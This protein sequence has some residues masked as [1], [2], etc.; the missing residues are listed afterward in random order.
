MTQV[1]SIKHPLGMHNTYWPMPDQDTVHIDRAK[2]SVVHPFMVPLLEVLQLKRPQWEFE[3]RGYGNFDYDTN[4]VKH[5]TFTIFDNGEKL[6]TIER[7][8]KS[9]S[10]VYCATNHR[11]SNKRQIGTRKT[12]KHLKT[13]VSEVLKEFY[14]L[15]LE[16]LA[17]EK[18]RKAYNATQTATHKVRREYARNTEALYEPMLK[19]LTSGGRWGEFAAVTDVPAVMQAKAEYHNLAGDAHAATEIQK[20]YHV[21]LIERPRDIVVKPSHG[22][23]FSTSLDKLPDDIKTSLALLKMSD[24]NTIINGSGVRTAED[25]FYII[26][27]EEA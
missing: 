14:P 9:G 7:D 12:S 13:I 23:A 3:A 17:N 4:Q 27:N 15:T 19:Y 1:N 10:A 16:E 8:Y 6:G 18:Y 25:T 21:V 2:N 24:V 22:A 11:I 20:A 26:T 5:D